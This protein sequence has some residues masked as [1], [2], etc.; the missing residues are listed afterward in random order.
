MGVLFGKGT[1][2][3]RFN[4]AAKMAANHGTLLALFVFTYKTTQCI[5]TRL[6]KTNSPLVSLIAGAIG[7]R[8]IIK[9]ENR[10]FTSI[11]RQLAYYLFSRVVEGIFL[12]MKKHGHIPNFEGFPISYLL[13]WGFVMYLFE[14]DKS[15]LNKS[16]VAS[17]D[18]I[19]KESDKDVKSWKEFI[20]VDLPQWLW[21]INLKIKF[22]KSIISI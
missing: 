12:W 15:I 3:E 9:P 20:P 2:R 13:S 11:N 4:W 16:L 6:F 18:F 19:Y 8:M 7:S 21:M 17:M 10:E 14:L 5:L 1:L 22:K